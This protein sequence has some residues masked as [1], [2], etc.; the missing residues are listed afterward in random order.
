MQ[1][2]NLRV[3]LIAFALLL[4]ILSIEALAEEIIL[5][6]EG[7]NWGWIKA[8]EL[9]DENP[10]EGEFSLKSL[11]IPEAGWVN[12]GPHEFK[13]GS[14]AVFEDDAGKLPVDEIFA[15]FYYD[16][17]KAP[18]G[19]WNVNFQLGGDWANKISK[20]DLGPELD[21]EEGYQLIRI[22]LEDFTPFKWIHTILR[23]YIHIPHSAQSINAF[24]IVMQKLFLVRF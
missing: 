11:E 13:N 8:M 21:A 23:L 1:A 22:A 12:H 15:E 19:S 20:N 17:G 5:Y 4:T 2:K 9:S 18:I 14:L 6:S 24:G 3:I 7:R 16:I 10:Y